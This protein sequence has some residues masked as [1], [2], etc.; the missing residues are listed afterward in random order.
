MRPSSN[1]KVPNRHELNLSRYAVFP[2]ARPRR[3]FR[4]W[5]A[6]KATRSA[7]AGGPRWDPSPRPKW[8]IYAA[9]PTMSELVENTPTA[10]PPPCRRPAAQRSDARNRPL[11]TISVQGIRCTATSRMP[12]DAEPVPIWRK[13]GTP[14][15]PRH[16]RSPARVIG[17]NCATGRG[18]IVA[19]ASSWRC[20]AGLRRGHGSFTTSRSSPASIAGVIGTAT[21]ARLA[22]G[23]GT[24][25]TQA[26][27]IAQPRGLRPHN[28][29]PASS[30]GMNFAETSTNSSPRISFCNQRLP[31]HIHRRRGAS[32]SLQ[33]ICKVF[34]A[35]P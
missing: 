15:H 24:I 2:T 13:D 31:H 8:W 21:S 11:S 16:W 19:V 10:S 6:W 4:P 33:R 27:Q 9:L 23:T 28:S 22:H 7:H 18:R 35:A 5:T 25:A 12:L 1:H 29:Y 32:I 14:T 34:R 26:A 3:R 20:S 30:H 17:E